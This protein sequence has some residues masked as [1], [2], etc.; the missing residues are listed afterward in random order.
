MEVEA[1][2]PPST[3]YGSLAV[4]IL[5]AGFPRLSDIDGRTREEVVS[6]GKDSWE[7]AF[8]E[9]SF[10]KVYVTSMR[11]RI[12]WAEGVR[13]APAHAPPTSAAVVAEALTPLRAEGAW[14]ALVQKL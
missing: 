2:P 5:M 13:N 12:S 11:K 10:T 1:N 4:R 8:L 6:M 9:K 3:R 7:Q 14:T